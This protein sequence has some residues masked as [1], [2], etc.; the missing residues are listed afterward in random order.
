MTLGQ[1]WTSVRPLL[2]RLLGLAVVVLLVVWGTFLLAVTASVALGAVAGGP[3]IGFGVLVSLAAAVLAVHLYV[4]LALAPSV[5]VL[6]RSSI[7]QSMRRSAALVKG[8]WW[9]VFGI[10]LLVL[11]IT[12][13]I[14]QVLQTPFAAQSLMSGFSGE[15]VSYGTTDVILQSIGSA[16]ALTLVMPFAAAVRALLYVDRRMRA[17]GLDVSLA[18]AASSRRA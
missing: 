2:L 4:R 13:F 7:A 11:V 3:G 17:E 10:L 14:S 16:L 1:A 12:S 5:M 9:R 18:A 15:A 6:E 8:D